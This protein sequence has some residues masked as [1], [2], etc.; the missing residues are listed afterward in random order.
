MS[1]DLVDVV[2]YLEDNEPLHLARLLVLLRA[3][4]KEDSSAIEGITKLAKLD[5]L[6]RYPAYFEMALIARGVR[7][8][9]IGI[10]EA[11]RNTIESSMVRYRF[12][13]WDHRYRKFLNILASKGL[14]TLR[15]SGRKIS[16]DLTDVGLEVAGQIASD[17]DFKAMAVRADLLSRELNLTATNLMNFIYET[18]PELHNMEFNDEINAQGLISNV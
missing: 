13:P 9:R 2:V 15:T 5:F 1:L 8:E 3:F 4:V 17:P 16:I 11:E 14:V 7:K 12:G 6:L 10:L 18:F